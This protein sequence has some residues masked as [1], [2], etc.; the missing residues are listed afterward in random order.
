MKDE[1][2][3]RVY[4][5]QDGGGWYT[6]GECLESAMQTFERIARENN[7]TNVRLVKETTTHE[8]IKSL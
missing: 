1:I 4:Y 5:N 2:Y 3:Y 6:E 8:I 7:A